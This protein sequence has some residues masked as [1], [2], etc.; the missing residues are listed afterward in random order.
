MSSIALVSENSSSS[1]SQLLV[2]SSK[3]ESLAAFHACLEWLGI[4]EAVEKARDA[5][6]LGDEIVEL[7]CSKLLEALE[8][9]RCLFLMKCEQNMIV[10]CSGVWKLPTGYINQ[11][12][13]T[14]SANDNLP[15]NCHVIR[16]RR[17]QSIVNRRRGNCRHLETVSF[18]GTIVSI[19]GNEIDD[20]FGMVG[21]SATAVD[22]GHGGDDVGGGKDQ[23]GRKNRILA[24]I[25][26]GEEVRA[27]EHN[28]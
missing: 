11:G 8:L 22:D 24:S 10:F 12:K 20:R 9:S 23:H 28:V 5:A 21:D 7:T 6:T 26:D 17:S 2:G 14:Q 16:I 15:G 25:A 27:T 1:G 4:K 18:D 3:Q 13:N 19:S